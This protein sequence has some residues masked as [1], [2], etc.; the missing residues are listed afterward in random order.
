VKRLA[1]MR[2]AKSSWDD[3]ALDDFDRPLN[4]RGWRAAR[5]MGAEFAT[6]GL[7]FD[8]VLASPAVR[9]RETIEG[10]SDEFDLGASISFDR[11]IYLASEATLVSRVRALPESTGAPLIVGHNPGLER[12]LLSL[13]HNDS[14]GFRAKVA[15]GYPTAAFAVVELPTDTWAQLEPGSGE[16]IELIFPRDLD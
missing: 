11:T 8:H 1:I 4:K 14:A 13:T 2:H 7:C 12:L 6:R 5:R 15:E 3:T 10:V 16:L 9:V